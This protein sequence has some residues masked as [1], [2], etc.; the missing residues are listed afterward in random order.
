MKFSLIIPVTPE[1][2]AEII[3]SIKKLDYP[4]SEFHIVVVKGR[5]PSGN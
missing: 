3:D 4:K 1:R 2:D 5:N